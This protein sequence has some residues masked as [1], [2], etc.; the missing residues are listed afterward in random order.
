MTT[1]WWPRASSS[2]SFSCLR[3]QGLLGLLI[4][5]ALWAVPGK[6][7]PF[8]EQPKPVHRI[9][10]ANPNQRHL[11]CDWNWSEGFF[12]FLFSFWGWCSPCSYLQARGYLKWVIYLFMHFYYHKNQIATF[13]RKKKCVCEGRWWWREGANKLKSEKGGYIFIK[14]QH[15]IN[16]CLVS[17][18]HVKFMG[19]LLILL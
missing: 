8:G 17:G 7:G 11:N 10:P 6:S 4:L 14:R 15:Q 18:T 9:S 1:W 3:I 19:C 13:E 5:C 16:F 12:G 2:C